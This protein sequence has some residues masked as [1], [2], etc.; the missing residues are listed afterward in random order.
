MIE[1]LLVALFLPT[2]RA[3]LVRGF[4]ILFHEFHQLFDMDSKT[5]HAPTSVLNFQLSCI[6]L[7]C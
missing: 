5:L 3:R 1:L 4:Q 7:T 6:D 2:F